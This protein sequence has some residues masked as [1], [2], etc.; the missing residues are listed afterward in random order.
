MRKKYRPNTEGKSEQQ[1]G[2]Q[3]RNDFK[4][5]RRKHLNWEK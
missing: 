3:K 1:I 5:A 2:E 4:L